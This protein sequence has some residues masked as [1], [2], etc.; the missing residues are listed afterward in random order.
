MSARPKYD[1]AALISHFNRE[2][3]RHSIVY[4]G[5]I[6][7]LAG[8]HVVSPP[9]IRDATNP[10]SRHIASRIESGELTHLR[11][12]TSKG[13]RSFIV[14]SEISEAVAMANIGNK[15]RLPPIVTL[16]RRMAKRGIS[17]RDFVLPK[18]VRSKATAYLLREGVVEPVS[19]VNSDLDAPKSPAYGIYRVRK[20]PKLS[21]LLRAV[22][23]LMELQGR[24]AGW[25]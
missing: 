13:P 16:L 11:L 3:E 6:N 22:K 20:R 21:K 23:R 4:L 25:E 14:D 2:L 15:K 9:F 12:E 7:R 1:H 8:G 17:K 10:L 24:E 19:P 5:D 18:P